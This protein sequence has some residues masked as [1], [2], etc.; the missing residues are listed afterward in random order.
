MQQTNAIATGIGQLAMQQQQQYEEAK[1]EKELAKAQTVADWLGPGRLTTLLR[2]TGLTDERALVMSLPIYKLLA[3][4]KKADKLSVLQDAINTELVNR[5]NDELNLE[6]S[7]GLFA[8]FTS[9]RWHRQNENS[10]TTGFFGNLFLFGNTNAEQ[11]QLLN[12]QV[13]L[14][15]SGDQSISQADAEKILKIPIIVPLE[16]D[17]YIN[18]ERANVLASIL[19][20]PGNPFLIYIAKHYKAF[21][22][23]LP[24][25]RSQELNTPALQPA[26]GIFHIY[27]LSLRASEYF[28]AQS[29]SDLP[30]SLPDPLELIKEIRM[31]RHWVPNIS[32]TFKKL[33]ELDELCR[34]GKPA[35][36]DIRDDSS[37]MSGLTAAST[38]TGIHS[39]LQQLSSHQGGGGGSRGSSGGGTA[40]PG[41]VAGA[42]QVLILTS[43]CLE[44]SRN[45]KLEAILSRAVMF[46]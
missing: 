32:T 35:R 22:A 30:V 31:T 18:I 13:S 16:E 25:W 46:V 1:R 42:A 17:S 41:G 12:A 5:G 44:K 3:E 14:A 34:L 38:L 24:K 19:L 4:A 21:L 37:M 43:L 45:S 8:N 2:F 39:L 9:M 40:P 11:Q 28:R 15:Q 23:F 36:P 7:A 26:K 20:P 27:Y 6:I 33:I 10:L 29:Q